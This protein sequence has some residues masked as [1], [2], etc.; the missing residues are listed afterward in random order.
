MSAFVSV[1]GGSFRR[2]SSAVVATRMFVALHLAMRSLAS[3]FQNAETF[4]ADPRA[5]RPIP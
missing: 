3:T 5:K 2:G 4:V 1:R